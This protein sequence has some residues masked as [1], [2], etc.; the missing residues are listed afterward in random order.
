[1]HLLYKAKSRFIYFSIRIRYVHAPKTCRRP[2]VLGFQR[3]CTAWLRVAWV[4]ASVG[5]S[6]PLT[7]DQFFQPLASVRSSRSL[8][9]D[10]TKE[11]STHVFEKLTLNFYSVTSFSRTFFSVIFV[12]HIIN[13]PE[14]ALAVKKTK[15]KK[16]IG[17]AFLKKSVFVNWEP[18][19]EEA[20][21]GC[22][23]FPWSLQQRLPANQGKP[24]RFPNLVVPRSCWPASVFKGFPG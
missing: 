9:G 22:L 14:A 24:S 20:T 13:S 4:G 1:M 21:K 8:G 17:L 2:S 23:S 11:L 7:A 15:T 10:C 12:C 16:Q 18:C 3:G 19:K 5:V 6:V